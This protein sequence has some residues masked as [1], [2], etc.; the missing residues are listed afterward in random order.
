MS[1]RMCTHT[2]MEGERGVK[3]VRMVEGEIT[4]PLTPSSLEVSDIH[5][6]AMSCWV[7]NP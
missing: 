1:K 3:T 2:Y 5:G 6:T 7:L 4:M